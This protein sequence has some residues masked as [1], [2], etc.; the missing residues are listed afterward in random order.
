M[1][2]DFLLLGALLKNILILRNKSLELIELI[3]SKL[4]LHN[5]VKNASEFS[6]DWL[7]RERSYLTVL[8]SKNKQISKEALIS[9]A[10]KLNTTGNELISRNAATDHQLGRELLELFDCCIKDMFGPEF[11]LVDQRSKIV[12]NK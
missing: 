2:V 12:V 10:N 8:R 7:C 5:L 6:I 3:Y 9:C 1:T 11:L 4:K